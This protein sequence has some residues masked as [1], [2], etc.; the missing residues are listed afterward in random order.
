MNS[1]N[2]GSS[3]FL[4][5]PASPSL[6]TLGAR[7]ILANNPSRCRIPL[8]MCIGSWEDSKSNAD[9]SKV[10][11]MLFS[12]FSL[13]LLGQA[14]LI[15]YAFCWIDGGKGKVCKMRM[16]TENSSERMGSVFDRRQIDGHLS[17]LGEDPV[18]R[19][20]SGETG[21][22]GWLE[23]KTLRSESNVCNTTEPYFQAIGT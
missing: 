12:F 19:Q 10:S 4:G 13:C 21:R 23:R 17:L 6:V 8:R 20:L 2:T 18:F 5:G 22:L 14:F 1:L 9:D 7:H 16:K 11:I 3:G 15:E